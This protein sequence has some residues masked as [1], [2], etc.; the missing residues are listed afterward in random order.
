LVAR[1]KELGVETVDTQ[2]AFEKAFQKDSVLLYQ[3]DDSH[4]NA[5]GVRIA[6][7]LLR[8][9]IEKGRSTSPLRAGDRRD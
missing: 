2:E 7:N 1:L 4:W 5:N 8:H 6:A 3:P 9:L